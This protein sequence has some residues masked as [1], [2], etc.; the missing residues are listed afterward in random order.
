LPDQLTMA[1]WFLTWPRHG[2]HRKHHFQQFLHCCL[3]T[4]LSNGLG[5]VA[6]LWGCCLA[7]AV[8]LVPYS[9]CQASCYNIFPFCFIVENVCVL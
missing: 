4:L 2:L 3:A 1:D 9:S 5:I 6:C 8:F 7:V